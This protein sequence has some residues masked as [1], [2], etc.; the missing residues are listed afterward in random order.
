MFAPTYDS[1]TNTVSMPIRTTW[2]DIFS[3][4]SIAVRA[5]LNAH[6][7]RIIVIP[8]DDDITTLFECALMQLREYY[9]AKLIIINANRN[10]IEAL[11][12]NGFV[13]PSQALELSNNPD[14]DP[15]L[16]CRYNGICRIMSANF[17]DLRANPAL[18][19]GF[20]T[21]GTQQYVLHTGPE[22]RTY[23]LRQDPANILRLRNLFAD[24]G[25]S[26]EKINLYMRTGTDGL[27]VLFENAIPIAIST[28]ATATEPSTLI[29][30][31]VLTPVGNMFYLSDTI[32][33]NNSDRPNITACL[34]KIAA[35]I[36]ATSNGPVYLIAPNGREEEFKKLGFRTA[37][38]VLASFNAPTEHMT[39]ILQQ[40]L[41]E[42]QIQT[43]R[44]PIYS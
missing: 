36:C 7:S 18:S 30:M 1:N 6:D 40:R 12:R 11:K 2:P 21:F 20:K 3:P 23:I 35:D 4:P 24:C 34:Y 44:A 8:T 37:R 31:C 26:Q 42:Y 15:Q 14:Q 41:A 33:A 17:E 38:N 29:G 16:R 28:Q 43:S 22:A 9:G 32:T 25:F 27:R 10:Q 39:E 5:Y 19:N 13:N